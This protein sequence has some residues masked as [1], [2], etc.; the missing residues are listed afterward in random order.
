[1][2][3]FWQ[4]AAAWTHINIGIKPPL[5]LKVNRLFGQEKEKPDDLFN[6]FYRTV[7]YA[8][9]RNR[10]FALGPTIEAFEELLVDELDRKYKNDRWRKYEDE[11]SEFKAI[12]W[13]RTKKGLNHINPKWLPPI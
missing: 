3:L 1:M 12:T 6:I 8:I 9:Y 10:K 4:R 7:R 11:P 13:L 2:E 5:G